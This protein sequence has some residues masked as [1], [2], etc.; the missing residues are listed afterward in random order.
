MPFSLFNYFIFVGLC[1]VYFFFSPIF[2]K[3]NVFI[4]L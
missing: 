2:Y 4:R 3:T 1:L